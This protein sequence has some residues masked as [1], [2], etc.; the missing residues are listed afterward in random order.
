MKRA[1]IVLSIY[2]LSGCM[3]MGQIRLDC[4]R[5]AESAN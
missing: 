5:T 2:S 4:T 1:I 3:I